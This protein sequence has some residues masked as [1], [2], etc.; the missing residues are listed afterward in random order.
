MSNQEEEK[1]IAQRERNRDWYYRN[2][3]EVLE[4]RKN[5]R[6]KT[7]TERKMAW[8]AYYFKNKEKI[9]QNAS[10]YYYKNRE[11]MLEYHRLYYLKKKA[12]RQAEKA[13]RTPKPKIIKCRT[14]Y[15]RENYLKNLRQEICPKGFM[16]LP[17]LENPFVM[18]FD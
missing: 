4:Y 14:H 13:A 15:K 5:W 11:K 1:N 12:Q 9:H 8:D 3:D 2:R 16:E 18:S 10:E 7:K 6:A 17:Q